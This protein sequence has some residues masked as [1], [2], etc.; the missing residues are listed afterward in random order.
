MAKIKLWGPGPSG[1]ILLLI[2]FV[3]MWPTVVCQDAK[4]TVT[5]ETVVFF[6]TFLSLV[7]FQLGGRRAPSPPPGY[8]YGTGRNWRGALK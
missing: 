7:A 1:S 2:T 4:K 6:V 3:R 5:E 8:A